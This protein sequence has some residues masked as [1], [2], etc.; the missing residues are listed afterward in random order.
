MDVK[1]TANLF[2]LIMSVHALLLTPVV[3][4]LNIAVGFVSSLLR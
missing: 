1:Q 3:K 4:Y 2:I